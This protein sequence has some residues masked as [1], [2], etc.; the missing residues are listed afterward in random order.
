MA[1]SYTSTIVN[2]NVTVTK[3]PTPSQ[4]QQSG[5]MVSFGGSTLT[6]GNYQYCTQLSDQ[7]SILE[8]SGTGNATEL[9]NEG[10]T[11]FAQGTS[12]G[13]YVLE[14]GIQASVEAQITALQTW[15][16]ANPGVF[17]AYLVPNEWDSG[18]DEVGSVII[19]NGGSGYT[20]A[21]TVTFSTPSGG[22]AA[23]GTAVIQSGAV[24]GVTITSPGTGY[25]AAPTVTFAA[26]TSGTTATGTVS[27]VSAFEV[28]AANYESPTGKT[29][30]FVNSTLANLALYNGNK[31]IVAVVP[32]PTAASTEYQAATLFYQWLVNSPSASNKLAPM[33]FRYVYGVT[34]W[35]QKGNGT[36]ITNILTA[37][38]NLILTGAEG[39]ISTSTIYR[40]MLMD[41]TQASWWY[42]VDWFQIQAK[43]ALAAAVINGSN[44]NPPLLYDQNGINSL[45]AVLQN[46]A[47][48]A[49]SFGCAA[50]I[51]LSATS[52]ADY[53]T[54]NPDNYSAGIY[55]GFSATVVGQNGFQT[56]TFNIDATQIA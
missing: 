38:G 6:S 32:S 15:I 50:S 8:P 49:V 55:G 16:T 29:Y 14:L 9:A 10:T 19:T 40:G 42:G 2:L 30:F 37:L 13:F 35:A 5:A 1:Q 41:G 26:P 3:A 48:S 28:M 31:S 39:G 51:T 4:L 20:T 47:T 17:Y 45:L 27:M 52:F 36:T 21:P 22:T 54:A 46:I 33:Q 7:T 11:H 18:S 25:T 24:T 56:I 44:S 23:T 43:Q 12:I 34:P 53:T